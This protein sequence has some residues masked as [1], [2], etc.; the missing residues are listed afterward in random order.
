MNQCKTLIGQKHTFASADRTL[1][2]T[3]MFW[4]HHTRADCLSLTKQ[5]LYYIITSRH[6]QNYNLF[7]VT[8]L[9]IQQGA[10][11]PDK[12]LHDHELL[13]L[14]VQKIKSGLEWS[15]FG[16]SNFF[17]IHDLVFH[18][19]FLPFFFKQNRIESHLGF[20]NMDHSDKQTFF[21]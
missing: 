10:Q 5:L 6:P 17:A 12:C 20:P 2:K 16:N 18:L 15:I 11:D 1:V 19:T 8:S 13:G 3:H 9:F 21:Q 7:C 14:V 4:V